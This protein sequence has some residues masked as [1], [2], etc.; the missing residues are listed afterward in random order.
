[1]KDLINMI[2]SVKM[3]NYLIEEFRL[4]LLDMPC[5]TQNHNERC[6][7]FTFN[8]LFTSF[9]TT[10]PALAVD[11]ATGNLY[12]ADR[13]YHRIMVSDSLGNFATVLHY[14]NISDPQDLVIHSE[15]RQGFKQSF[16]L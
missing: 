10:S 7:N 11:W 4:Y 1:M 13:G 6:K 2:M 12:W 3:A 14:T 15:K 9:T 8:V 5:I 16:L